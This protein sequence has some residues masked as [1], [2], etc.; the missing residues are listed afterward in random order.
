MATAAAA[1]HHL[2]FSCD[3]PTN[4]TYSDNVYSAASIGHAAGTNAS[5]AACPGPADVLSCFTSPAEVWA[6]LQ[7]LPPGRRAIS[8]EVMP[9]ILPFLHVTREVNGWQDLWLPLDGA[10]AKL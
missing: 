7:P 4:A 5:C 10:H 6:L 1:P 3:S 9:W 8:L 2:A